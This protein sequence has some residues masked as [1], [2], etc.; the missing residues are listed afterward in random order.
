MNREMEIPVVPSLVC[1]ISLITFS[2]SLFGLL[3]DGL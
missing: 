2:F 3:A 1:G